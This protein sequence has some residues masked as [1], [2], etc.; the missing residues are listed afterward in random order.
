MTYSPTQVDLIRAQLETVL[1]SDQFRLS[2]KL[3]AFLRFIVE[4]TIEGRDKNIKE[5]LVGER[6]YGR[7]ENYDP[8]D[9]SIV[10]QEAGRLRAKLNE[11]N[12]AEGRKDSIIF[13]VPKGGYVPRIDFRHVPAAGEPEPL[14][15]WRTRPWIVGLI[16][17]VIVLVLLWTIASTKGIVIKGIKDHGAVDPI[18]DVVVSA[19]EPGP[20]HYLIVEPL[21]H[22]GQR[23]VQGEIKSPRST[24]RA[25]F[26]DSSTPPGMRFRVYVLSTKSKLP[27]GPISEDPGTISASDPIYVTLRK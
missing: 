15:R 1:I 19:V 11:Y 14:R 8:K 21:D 6:V 12:A 9:D 2:T 7:P 25:H 16:C 3:Q 4:E 18:E 26:G 10:R 17:I 23:W 5:A 27:V 24:I 22:S 13:S 20:N